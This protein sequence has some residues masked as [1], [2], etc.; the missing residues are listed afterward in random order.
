MNLII[1]IIVTFYFYEVFILLTIIDSFLSF[2]LFLI[3]PSGKLFHKFLKS[4]AK[5]CLF[6]S[7]TRAILQNKNKY[8]SDRESYIIISNHQSLFDI[9]VLYSIFDKLSFKW[10]IKKSLFN[11]PFFG[12]PLLYLARYIKLD[13]KNKYKA[14]KAIEKSVEWIKKGFSMI[15]FPEGTRSLED[16][17]NEFKSGSI[18][19][20][21]LSGRPI[22]PV[23]MRG[24]LFIKSK[25]AFFIN[26]VPV[27]IK[28]LDKIE[29]KDRDKSEQKE[30]LKELQNNM[31]NVYN[32][33]KELN[34]N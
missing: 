28:I 32:E 25:K 3:S 26:P 1:R 24:T 16:K 11:I 17:I 30:L 22:I 14:Y 10:V 9:I 7:G 8:N 31:Q 19:I 4:S 20:A 23:V 12:I 15:I 33:L 6:F 21:F 34:Y 2:P 27:V 5:I 13:R 29:V 18:K